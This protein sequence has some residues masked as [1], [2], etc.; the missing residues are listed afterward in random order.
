MKVFTENLNTKAY[1]NKQKVKEDS[2]SEQS[3]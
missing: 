2:W 1:E 3:A